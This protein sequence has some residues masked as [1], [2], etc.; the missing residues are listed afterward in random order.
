MSIALVQSALGGNVSG[1]AGTTPTTLTTSAAGFSS[2]TTAGNVLV[3]VVFGRYTSTHSGF[4]SGLNFLTPVTM[5][6][7]WVAAVGPSWNDSTNTTGGGAQIFYAANAPSISSSTTTTVQIQSSGS[8]SQVG[9][10]M[11][12]EF[13]LYEFSG[14]A[15]SSPIDTFR[16]PAHSTGTPNPGTMVTSKTDL[17][18]SIFSG[19]SGNISAGP[20]YSLGINATVPTTGQLQYELNVAPGSVATA[21]SG[22]Q[23][24]YGASAVA[25]KGLPASGFAFGSLIGF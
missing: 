1:T 19:D 17:I 3:C 22:S 9:G 8:G 2:N 21:F 13:M 24:N 18:M 4:F 14:V 10:P 6:I 5:G 11:S 12:G 25:F 7:T 15:H 16:S 23:T 20:G